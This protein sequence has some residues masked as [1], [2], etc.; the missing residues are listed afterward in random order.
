MFLSWSLESVSVLMC[1][2]T[3]S[4]KQSSRCECELIW[5]FLWRVAADV[6]FFSGSSWWFGMVI[7]D[8]VE[9]EP[10]PAESARIK[11]EEWHFRSARL[12]SE[13]DYRHL[14]GTNKTKRR[15]VIKRATT[16]ATCQITTAGNI[17]IFDGPPSKC[18]ANSPAVWTPRTP[19][20]T[21]ACST[22]GGDRKPF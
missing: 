21:P 8:C 6:W 11:H 16:P 1:F 3:L 18:A 10:V 15:K 4:T 12:I 19:A 14:E 17:S 7:P 20:V 5:R 22:Y 9:T 13:K 2:E